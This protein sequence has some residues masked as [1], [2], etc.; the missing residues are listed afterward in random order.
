VYGSFAAVIALLSWLSLH[1]MLALVGVEANAAL[2]RR[3]R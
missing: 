2:D 1:A 3:R